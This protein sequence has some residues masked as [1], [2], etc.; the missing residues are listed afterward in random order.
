MRITG[1][2]SPAWLRRLGLAIPPDHVIVRRLGLTEIRA[3]AS[4]GMYR[5]RGLR[6]GAAIALEQG[7]SKAMGPPLD[8]PQTHNTGRPRKA[9]SDY[10]TACHLA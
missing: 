9:P 7:K 1:P 8:L 10:Q 5:R 3:A 4:Y 6:A 2:V